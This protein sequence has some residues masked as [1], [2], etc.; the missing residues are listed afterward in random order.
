ML[1]TIL[2]PRKPQVLTGCS[3]A[4]YNKPDSCQGKGF[5]QNI[6]DALC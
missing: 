6:T 1:T 5:V 3:T 2:S 4:A